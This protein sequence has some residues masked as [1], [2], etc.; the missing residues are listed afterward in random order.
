MRVNAASTHAPLGHVR[1]LWSRSSTGD[2]VLSWLMV[3][4]ASSPNAPWSFRAREPVA[5]SSGSEGA[6]GGWESHVECGPPDTELGVD[7]DGGGAEWLAGSPNDR[8][9][10]SGVSMKFTWGEA[11]ARGWVRG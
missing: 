1:T 6:E 10:R 7:G 9:D 2:G 8:L 11:A 3:D 5:P 4:V